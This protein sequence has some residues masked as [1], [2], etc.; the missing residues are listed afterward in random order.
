MFHG[1]TIREIITFVDEIG[2]VYSIV[3]ERGA[4]SG[5]VAPMVVPMV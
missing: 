3:C 1:D 5:T 2:L 4:T